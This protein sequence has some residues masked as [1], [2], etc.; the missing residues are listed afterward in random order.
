[1]AAQAIANAGIMDIAAKLLFRSEDRNIVEQTCNILNNLA[2]Y[3]SLKATLAGSIPHDLLVAAD[4]LREQYQGSVMEFLLAISTGSSSSAQAFSTESN[5]KWIREKL[6]SPTTSVAGFAC[7]ILGNIARHDSLIEPIVQLAP[8]YRLFSLLQS[9]FRASHHA[10]LTADYRHSEYDVA[11]QAA[12]TLSR[13]CRVDVGM[14]SVSNVL[15]ELLGSADDEVVAS[16]CRLLG[17]L[18]ENE[19]L[20]TAVA[21]SACCQYLVSF[22][23]SAA[24]LQGR[25]VADAM[26]EVFSSSW[27]LDPTVL[28]DCCRMLGHLASS[29]HEVANSVDFTPLLPL[30]CNEGKAS[31]ELA[32][33]GARRLPIL[34][35]PSSLLHFP[36]LPLSPPPPAASPFV[37]AP[38]PTPALP[39]PPI[40]RPPEAP[41]SP[42]FPRCHGATTRPPHPRLPRP[43]LLRRLLPCSSYRNCAPN[44]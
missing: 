22:I 38:A 12:Y 39:N 3:D 14:Y 9:G 25:A 36:C 20:N 30:L 26:N 35:P 13:I 2:R 23:G 21:K 28:V 44:V 43:S 31:S 33:I 34:I 19:V 17:S 27:F 15:L 6:D 4:D 18:A 40:R 32:R 5:L 29:S 16:S 11:S 37:A 8:C 41:R 1:M 10:D 24:I 7:R 42:S